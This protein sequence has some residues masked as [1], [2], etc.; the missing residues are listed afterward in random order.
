MAETSEPVTKGQNFGFCPLKAFVEDNFKV[1]Q[2]V[3]IISNGQK[4]LSEKEKMLVS[5]IFFRF[6]LHAKGFF[7]KSRHYAVCN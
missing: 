1:A 4:I 2:T 5:S 6:P 3:K 7:P